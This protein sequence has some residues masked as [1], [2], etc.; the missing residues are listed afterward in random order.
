MK[1]CIID[2]NKGVCSFLQKK[3]MQEGFAVDCYY[4]GNSGLE[5]LLSNHYEVIVLDINLPNINGFD[6]AA[7]VRNNKIDSPII[8][9]TSRDK[10]DDKISGFSVGAD[11]YLSKP[12]EFEEL[13]L[14]VNAILKRKYSNYKQNLVIGELVLNHKQKSVEY[15]NKPIHITKKEFDILYFLMLKSPEVI[16]MD[17]IIANC[18]DEF[19]NPCS[20]TARVHISSLRRKINE[21][22]GYELLKNIKGKGY[23]L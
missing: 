4:D 18:F 23:T 6:I 1:I 15:A 13:K 9:L 12:F 5:A 7:I 11:D 19:I 3:F 8:M 22:C 20:N 2:D 21:I 17:T 14:R 16:A 10:L